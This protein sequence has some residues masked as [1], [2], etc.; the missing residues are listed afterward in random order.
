MIERLESIQRVNE[1]WL[2]PLVLNGHTYLSSMGIFW[3]I[4]CYAGLTNLPPPLITFPF[5]SNIRPLPRNV[6]TYFRVAQ[7]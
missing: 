4:S 5:G 1:D 7:H 2:N 3:S 6:P